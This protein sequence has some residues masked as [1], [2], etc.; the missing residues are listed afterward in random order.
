M[1]AVKIAGVVLAAG[2]STRFGATKQLA[3]IEGETLVAR[4]VRTAIE[5]GLFPVIA[6]V[7]DA[8]LDAALT[9]DL[10]KLGAAVL[11][12]RKT[13]E[14]LS[15]SIAIGVGAAKVQGAEGIVLMT[16]DQPAL[17]VEHLHALVAEP[18]KPAG[19]AYSGRVGVPAFFPKASFDSLL[20]LKGDAGA[21]E[22]LLGVRTVPNEALAMD[23]DTP[24]DLERARSA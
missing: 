3:E 19:S 5:A 14:G 11:L 10:Q 24:A 23:I 12:N 22:L 18:D 6:V 15:S 7:R 21:R 2:L 9:G 20:A 1:P 13:H 16:C 8:V 4:A 17:S